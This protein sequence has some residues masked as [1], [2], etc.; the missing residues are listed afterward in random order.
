VSI[1]KIV[2]GSKAYE[3]AAN[4]TALDHFDGLF[5]ESAI[6][7]YGALVEPESIVLDVGANVGC[8]TLF[9]A[10]NVKHVHAFEPSPTT[11]P[12]LERNTS[13]HDNVTCVQAGLGVSR[14]SLTLTS[15][16]ENSTGAF[17]SSIDS[18]PTGHVSHS[19]SILKGDDYCTDLSVNLIKIDT[20]GFEAN[21]IKG[22]EKTI[23]TQRPV[24]TLELNHWCLNA[25]QRTSVPDYFDFLLGIFPLLFAVDDYHA[26]DLRTAETRFH[27][28]YQHI[29][30]GKYLNLVGC[31]H[32]NQIPRFLGN[33]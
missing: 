14:E 27:V 5:D 15:P 26:A 8:T 16:I 18:A 10:D 19:I 33:Y 31:F 4:D 7:L 32:G 22:L 6:R 30:N 17:V 29:N 20:E 25:F 13:G 2:I 28:M 21:V 23:Q 24:V 1:T 12:F 11:Y 3:I 9:F